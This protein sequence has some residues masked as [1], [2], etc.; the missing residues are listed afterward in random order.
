MLTTMLTRLRGLLQR[1]RVSREVK[2]E[3]PHH[4]ATDTEANIKQGTAPIQ[5]RRAA[6]RD[7]GGVEQTKQTIRDGRALSVEGIWQDARY[8]F[9]VMR[10]RPGFSALVIAT[11]ALGI[12]VNTTSVAVAYGILMRPLPYT[13]PSRLVILNLLF[14][15][16]GDLGYSPGVLQ[17]WLPRLRTVEAAAGFYRREVTVHS[18]GRSTVVPAALVTDRFFDVL[19]TAAAS[20]HLPSRSNSLDVVVGRRW[21]NQLMPGERSESVGAPISISGTPHTIGGVMPSDFAFPDDEIGVWLQSPALIP[22]TKSESSGYSKIVARLKPGVT[23]DQFRDDANRVRLELNPRSREIVSAEVLGESVVGGLR[24]LLTVALAGALLVLIVACANVA[25]LFIGR[26]VARR[27]ELG[28][29]M[30]LGATA[31]QLVRSVLVETSLTALMAALVGVGVGAMML[32]IF[33]GQAAA[34]VPGLHRVAM[35]LPVA[36]TIAMLTIVVSLVCGAVP[37]WH[38]ARADFSSFLRETTT[39]WPRVWR[40][41]GALVVAQIALSCVLLIGAGLLMRTVFVLMHE[42]HGFQPAG[43]LEAKFVLSDTV[44]FDGTGRETFVRDMLDRVRAIPGVQHAGFGT[45]L[46]PR[47]PPITMALRLLKDNRDETRFMKVGT[48]TPGYLRALGARFVGGRDFD[49]ADTQAGA[50]VVILSESAAQFYFP[51]EDPVGRTISRLPAVFRIAGAPRVVGVVSDI[52][53][54]GLDSPAPSAVYIPWVLRPLGSG[55]LIVRTSGGDPMRM[56][57]DIRAAAQAVDPT[58]PMPELQSLEQAMAQS[59]SNRRVRA[60]PAIG[61]GLLSLAVAFVGVLA[62]LSTLVAERRRDLAIR[63]AL[64]ASPARLTWSIVS[65]GLVLTA[66][67]LVLGLGL[68]GVAARGLSSLV[69]GVSPYDALTFAGTA[70]VIGGGAA[71]MTYA[72][73]R[74]ARAV[75]PL[76][77]LKY[78]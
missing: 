72:A 7:L 71:M 2:D 38:A 20:G 14:P 60:L 26:D 24:K 31:S 13:E 18:A 48:A 64:G 39:A 77:V 36:F 73:A 45:N 33:V 22:G 29:R 19:G 34:S 8:A 5:G 12:G 42:D 50:A 59:I 65:Q 30:A 21:M 4:G 17:D 66:F 28:A 46:P 76:V 9:R 78:E 54:E 40:L 16:G 1:G 52:K 57:A 70:V 44:L 74:R 35:G 67:G 56:A 15:D 69:Y 49:E 10:K 27:R 63:A 25:T 3:L 55:Y 11:L 37:A 6:L 23:L 51:D 47:P 68:G 58:V 53:Y 61:F 41:R 75:D 62:T 43:A 32:R